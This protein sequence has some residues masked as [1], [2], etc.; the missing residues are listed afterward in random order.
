MEVLAPAKI[1]LGLS[2]LGRFPNGY[3]SIHT[4]F[5][6]LELGDLLQIEPIK[7]GIEL[8]VLGS[9]LSAGSD[10]LV[11]RVAEIYLEAIGWPG[12]IRIVLDK[13]LP[14]AAGLGGGSSDAARVLRVL[15][16]I[17]PVYASLDLSAIAENLGA[18]V[19]FFL[20]P[21]LSEGRGIGDQLRPLPPIDQ[22]VVL[23][24][25]DIKLMSAWAYKYLLPS[26]WQ[27]ELDVKAI[28][29]ALKSGQEPPYWNTLEIPVFRL[30]PSLAELKAA[31]QQAGLYGCLMSGSGS[32]LFGLA[33]D[34]DHAAFVA[35]KLSEQFPRFWIRA[36]RTLTPSYPSYHPS[37]MI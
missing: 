37:I 8:R 22:H 9:D 24:N 16:E 11:Y 14:I 7:E 21:G 19:P 20:Q 34:A 36:T 13:R 31:L 1:N 6:A 30:E 27:S 28:M 10:N 33:T 5:A 3:H 23:L 12:G 18:D 4:L 2:V 35:Q 32:T 26:E 15:S 29:E 25:P 17:Y